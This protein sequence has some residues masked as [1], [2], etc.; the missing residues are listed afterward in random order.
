VTE[1]H[2]SLARIKDKTKKVAREMESLICDAPGN[3]RRALRRIAEGDLGRLQEPSV[4][5]LGGR[6]SRNLERLTV[7][8]VAAA[9]VI[10]GAMLVAAPLGAWHHILG[11]HMVIGG[12]S[13]TLVICVGT[14]RRD[15][16][17]R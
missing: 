15:R 2:F 1:Q 6:V 16:E 3:T 7:A 12:I 5:A 9:L 17:R 14:M 8:I 11:N 4:E 10:G 13:G